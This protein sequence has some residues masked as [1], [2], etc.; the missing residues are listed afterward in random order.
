MKEHRTITAVLLLVLCL[1]LT[2]VSA[3]PLRRNITRLAV[4][5]A[6]SGRFSSS[7]S[8]DLVRMAIA[9]ECQRNVITECESRTKMTDEAVLQLAYQLFL[10]NAFNLEIVSNTALVPISRFEPSGLSDSL[11]DPDTIGVMYGTGYFQLQVFLISEHVSCWQVGINAKHDDPPP[12][13]LE[14]YFDST[15]VDTVSYDLGDQSWQTQSVKALVEPNLHWLRIWFANDYLDREIGVDRNA[16]LKYV[17]ITQLEDSNC[18][19]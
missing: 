17:E 7:V 14:V 10:N 5:N 13:E 2:G 8:L 6:F 16:Y 11:L 3:D 15:R 18:E 4:M 12:V 1:L 9:L 19:H